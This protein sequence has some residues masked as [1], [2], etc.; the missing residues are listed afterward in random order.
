MEGINFAIPYDNQPIGGGHSAAATLFGE[1][2]LLTSWIDPSSIDIQNKYKQLTRG[3]ES[4]EDK[5]KACLGYVSAIPYTQFVRVSANVAGRRFV[6]PDAWLEPSQAIYAG[7]LN[8]ANK[9]YLLTSLL[10][11]ELPAENVWACLGNLNSDSQDGHAWTYVKLDA[12]YI[13]ET[14]NPSVRDKLIPIETVG[15]IYED[16]VYVNDVSVRAIPER[17]IREPFSS[18]YNCLPFL[19]DYLDRGLCL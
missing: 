4:T 11:Q 7:K 17:K 18:C 1:V 19:V 2:K 5:I 10:R 9:T 16:I 15:N 14:T 13:L 6:Q 3:L 8:C 12:D